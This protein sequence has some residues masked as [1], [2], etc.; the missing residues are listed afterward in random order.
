MSSMHFITLLP[1]VEY[2]SAGFLGGLIGSMVGLGGG[3]V[4][5]PF[6]LLG[7]AFLPAKVAGTSIVVVFVTAIISASQYA[8]H[9]LIDWKLGGVLAGFSVPGA[10]IGA[11]LAGDISTGLFM[12][13]FAVDLLLVASYLF[14]RPNRS[15]RITFSKHY[16]GKI[17]VKEFIDNPGGIVAYAI[18]L[19]LAAMVFFPAGILAGLVGVGGGS[20]MVP[21]ML[22]ILGMP[23]AM[24]AATSMM[25]MIFNAGVAGVVQAI[26]GHVDWIAAALLSVGAIAGSRIGPHLSVSLRKE[27][28]TRLMSI[29]LLVTALTVLFLA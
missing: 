24:V 2:F 9:H 10:I 7:M 22:L 4:I 18:N 26:L 17:R 25:V 29:V 12:E 16:K 1:T 13:I 6:L 28:L 14:F 15:L 23:A 19:P 27:H 20:I 21:G 8:R 11:M 5:V 3:F